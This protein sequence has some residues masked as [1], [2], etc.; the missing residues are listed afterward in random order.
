M[1]VTWHAGPD[2]SR[3][4]C[5]RWHLQLLGLHIRGWRKVGMKLRAIIASFPGVL[6][7]KGGFQRGNL[8]ESDPCPFLVAGLLAG[9]RRWQLGASFA[10]ALLSLSWQAQ[11]PLP[12]WGRFFLESVC[13]ER[14]VHLPSSGPACRSVCWHSKCGAGI[15]RKARNPVCRQLRGDNTSLRLF[16]VLAGLAGAGCGAGPSW[17]ALAGSREHLI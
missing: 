9:D 2:C 5:Q 6:T 3:A 13:L 16:C 14:N 17:H 4:P 7:N 10:L 12:S 15:Q 11:Q 8:C 1:P